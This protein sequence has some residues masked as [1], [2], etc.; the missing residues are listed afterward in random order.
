MNN[1]FRAQC[2]C[3]Q[4]AVSF[5][6]AP[7]AQLVCHCRDC[8]T[9]SGLPYAN[10][11]FFKTEERCAQGQFK[12][13]DMKGGSGKPKQYRRCSKCNDFVY[14]TVDV[15]TG[16]L[17]VAADKLGPPYKFKPMA[18]VWTSE[19]APEV[20]IPSGVFQFPK[21]PPFRPGKQ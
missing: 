4:L 8:Q 15:L 14:A 17:G 2:Q 19:K 12:A 5:A 3:G 6:H 11:A 16:L 7:V 20:E 21:A 1:T 18:H 10:V 13:I 9:I